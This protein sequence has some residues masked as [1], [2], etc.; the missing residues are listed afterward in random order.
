MDKAEKATIISLTQGTNSIRVQRES[1]GE[2][3]LNPRDFVPQS[4]TEEDQAPPTRYGTRIIITESE[5]P[6]CARCG[7]PP[8]TQ[9]KWYREAA[10]VE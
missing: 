6:V 1:G 2:L 10:P 8:M 9:K 4:D 3:F 5:P 7:H